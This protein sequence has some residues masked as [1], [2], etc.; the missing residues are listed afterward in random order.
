M[1]SGKETSFNAPFDLHVAIEEATRLYSRE[2]GR[3]D[4]EFNLDLTD[5]P[6][7]VVGDSKKI[8]TVVQNLTANACE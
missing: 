2:A 6:T 7:I 4:I 5:S 1:E 3:R 8:R